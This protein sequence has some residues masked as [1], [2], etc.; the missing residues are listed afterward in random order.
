MTL[1]SS[2]Q[3]IC[4]INVCV[5]GGGVHSVH[6]MK[7]S[8]FTHKMIQDSQAEKETWDQQT[9]TDKEH[10]RHID[11]EFDSR[12]FRITYQRNLETRKMKS[13]IEI[14]GII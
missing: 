9:E 8:L 1:G 3:H 5:W 13:K 6:S 4:N 14:W 11:I 7:M 10:Y 12:D 2:E